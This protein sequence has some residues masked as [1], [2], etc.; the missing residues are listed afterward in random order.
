MYMNIQNLLFPFYDNES[1][2]SNDGINPAD[3]SKCN[4]IKKIL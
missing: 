4:I 3:K 1:V 2:I